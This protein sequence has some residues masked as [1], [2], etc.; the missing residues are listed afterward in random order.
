MT[1]TVAQ[2]RELVGWIL[3]FGGG[4]RVISPPALRAAVRADA[5]RILEQE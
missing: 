2:T 4:V 5:R 1:L 3:S